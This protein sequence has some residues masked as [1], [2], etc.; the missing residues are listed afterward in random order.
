MKKAE[1]CKASQQTY[2]A[3]RADR[4]SVLFGGDRQNEEMGAGVMLDMLAQV[5]EHALGTVVIA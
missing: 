3:K 4:M 1:R 2:R 5:Y